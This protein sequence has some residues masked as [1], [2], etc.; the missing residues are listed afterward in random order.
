MTDLIGWQYA[1]LISK[2]KIWKP[3]ALSHAEWPP[4]YTGVWNWRRKT[5]HKFRQNPQL[6]EAAK[7]YY[8][9]RPAH[10][11]MH[12]M[13]T[14]DP[15]KRTLKW[16]PFIFFLKQDEFIQFLHALRSEEQCG[17]VEKSRDMGATWGA[18]GYSVWS[19]RFIP[20]DS[21]GWGSRKQEL[22]D[23]LGNADS[24]FEKMRLIIRRLPKIWR[25]EGFIPKKHATFMKLLNPENGSTITGEAGDSIGRGGRK[26]MYFLDEAAHVEHAESIE[27]S[28]GDN[29]NVRVD[30]SSVNGLDNV[31][32]NRRENGVDWQP[33][34]VIEKGQVRVFVMDWSDH[35]E[36]DRE[37]YETRK[38]KYDREGLQHVFAQETDR[39][40]SAAVMN[41]IIPYEWIEHAVDAHL[42]IP[43]LL[44][45]YKTRP[46]VWIAGLDVADEGPDRNSLSMREWIIWRHCEEWGERDPGV[47][48]RRAIDGV[49]HIRGIKVM[50]DCIGVGATV[51]SEYN[52]LVIDEKKLN[53]E[54]CEFVAWNA[55]AAVVN[56][57]HRIIPDDEKSML[58]KD[59]YGNM[60][61]QAWW[62]IR[63]R[64]YKTWKA[65]TEG[66]VYPSGELISLDG[67]MPLLKQLMK[68]LAQPTRSPNGE[69]KMIVDKKPDG[70]KSPNLADGGVQM[71]FPIIN[72]T[73]Q[74]LVGSYG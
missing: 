52:R 32:F 23:T 28:L 48:A 3:F 41:T 53:P 63:T 19:W 72:D 1:E 74:P 73:N 44:A 39:N 68:E 30:M 40:Y 26:S 51:K 2:E 25:P 38:A 21:I 17:L 55:G 10:F 67:S 16:M 45:E 14:Y 58:N 5:L 12:W 54:E 50:Y 8:S 35:P 49:R 13:D 71:Y 36:K 7:R 46:N 65:V 66:I 6:F 31:F 69:L 9:T 47:T 59:F 56:P 33:G 27:S 42:K 64:F 15:R 37:W 20:N 43:Y 24:I 70:R 57:F 18:C 61:A 4:D 34:V 22:V 11:I 62:S 29:T 60:K